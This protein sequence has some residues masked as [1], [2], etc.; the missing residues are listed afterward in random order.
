MLHGEAPEVFA[1]RIG[2][3]EF[4]LDLLHGQKTGFYLDQVASYAQ[5]APHARGRRVLDCFA[6][7]GG[8]A[9]ACAKAGASA[10]SA[11]DSSEDCTA[12]IS[13]NAA[14]NGLTVEAITGNV[15]GVL[16]ELERQSATYDLIILDPP[17]FTKNKA[18]LAE[19]DRGYKEIH[20]RALRLLSPDGLLATF[21]CSHHVSAERFKAIIN[22]ASVDAKRAL[23][24]VGIY[25]QSLDHPIVPLLPETEYLKG[26]L[27]ELM[28]GR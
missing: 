21:C 9:L 4:E 16:K 12:A 3:L 18:K 27:F 11:I 6:N 28:P 14:R 19:A 20:L 8:F 13:R 23:R 1:Q 24:Q 10:V 7:A 5:V 22:D 25:S 17:S 15:F 2:G 26:Y